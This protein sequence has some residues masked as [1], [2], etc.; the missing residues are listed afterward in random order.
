MTHS[1]ESVEDM[2]VRIKITGYAD[3]ILIFIKMFLDI[4][5]ECAKPGG[6]EKSLVMNAIESKKAYYANDNSN[7]ADHAANNRLLFLFPHTFH[8]SL[9]EKALSD[10]LEDPGAADSYM[11]CPDKF[12]K[13]M[14]LEQITSVQVLFFGNTSE[15]QAKKFCENHIVKQFKVLP[16]A[17]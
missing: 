13:E 8:N 1:F 14:I 9:M 2:A 17:E 5:L 3:K 10:Q 6:F 12:L 7:V 4:M 15:I 16:C 11:H